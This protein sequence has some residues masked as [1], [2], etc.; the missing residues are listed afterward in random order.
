MEKLELNV[1]GMA[2]NWEVDL[3]GAMADEMEMTVFD[4]F[5]F[6]PPL[7]ELTAQDPGVIPD[8]PNSATVYN[9]V[10]YQ[11][12]RWPH[13]DSRDGQRREVEPRLINSTVVSYLHAKGLKV[14]KRDVQTQRL[15]RLI[16]EQIRD[17]GTSVVVDFEEEFWA[18]HQNGDTE[19][20]GS[21][22]DGSAFY[23]TDHPGYD[24]I[25]GVETSQANLFTLALDATN[26][27]TV[28]ST[29]SSYTDQEGNYLTDRSRYQAH[30]CVSPTLY[31]TARDIFMPALSGGGNTNTRQNEAIVHEVARLAETPT[32]WY[33]FLTPISGNDNRAPLLFVNDLPLQE[34]NQNTV[35]WT[36]A[37]GH[38]KWGTDV[39]FGFGYW[40]WHLAARSEP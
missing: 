1:A 14:P 32:R 37:D 35:E 10:S 22:Y 31:P 19:A 30:I 2:E 7:A 38:Y 26:W 23:A 20:Y 15:N 5:S 34:V 39:G 11:Q 3:S 25:A 33:V 6:E 27:D 9:F 28:K 24:R 8:L 4:Q 36:Y 29:M 12:A 16:R 40:H 21:S 18:L 13:R 17:L